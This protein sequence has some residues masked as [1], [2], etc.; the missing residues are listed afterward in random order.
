MSPLRSRALGAA[1]AV[2]SVCRAG[3]LPTDSLYQLHAEVTTQQGTA[4]GFNLYQ[5]HP[6]L[7]SMFYGSC[8]SYCPM[9]ITALQVYESHLPEDSRTRLRVLLVSFD[10]MHDTPERLT[11]LA[12]LH[13]TDPSRWTFASASEPGARKIAELL[14]FRY[15]QLPDGS[16]EHSQVITLIDGQGRVLANTTK[17]TGDSAFQAQLQAAAAPGTR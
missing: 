8:P 12:H 3:D 9:L 14:G 5:G 7:L 17:L 1:L 10:A 4:A 13:R 6:T 16:F 11:E 15:R 2:L